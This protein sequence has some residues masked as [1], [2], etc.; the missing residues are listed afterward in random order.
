MLE[1]I[2]SVCQWLLQV[3]THLCQHCGFVCHELAAVY[4][5]VY[6]AVCALQ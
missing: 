5:A 6:R 1:T 2:F 4:A 3:Y